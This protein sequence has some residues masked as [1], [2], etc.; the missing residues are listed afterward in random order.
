MSKDTSSF[1]LC[2]TMLINDLDSST[3]TWVVKN[4]PENSSGFRHLCILQ[5]AAHCSLRISGV[6]VY[7][8]VLS[9]IDIRSS[10]I[11][12]HEKSIELK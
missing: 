10:K 4:V 7:G 9:A 5:K 3:A 12:N 8:Q 6:E 2:E 11:A 1:L